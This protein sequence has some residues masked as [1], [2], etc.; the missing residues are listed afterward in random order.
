M[1]YRQEIKVFVMRQDI[2]LPIKSD[3]SKIAMTGIGDL[4]VC[5]DGQ[6][7]YAKDWCN[8]G[9]PSFVLILNDL[10]FIEANKHIFELIS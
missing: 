8:N 1:S 3:P 6:K 5:Y 9:D 10:S 4:L 2:N 7:V